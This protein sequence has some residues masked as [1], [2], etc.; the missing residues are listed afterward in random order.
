MVAMV[1]MVAMEAMEAMEAMVAAGSHRRRTAS[2]VAWP[3]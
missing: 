1:A 2:G 3:G